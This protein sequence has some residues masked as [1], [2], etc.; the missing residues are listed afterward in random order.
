MGNNEGIFILFGNKTDLKSERAV[1]SEEGK[2]FTNKYGFIFLE[3]SA[4]IG[5]NIYEL[6]IMLVK[7]ITFKQSGC[8]EKKSNIYSKVLNLKKISK[9][10]KCC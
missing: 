5:Q 8:Q 9:K 10:E 3:G 4:K 2:L 1:T 7:G 6:F